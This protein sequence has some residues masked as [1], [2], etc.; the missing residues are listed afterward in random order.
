MTALPPHGH[1][2]NNA[3]LGSFAHPE[4]WGGETLGVRNPDSTFEGNPGLGSYLALGTRNFVKNTLEDY[5]N[6]DGPRYCVQRFVD[7]DVFD[8][9]EFAPGTVIAAKQEALAGR[10]KGLS[11]DFEGVTPAPV[12]ASLPAG[13]D[14]SSQLEILSERIGTQSLQMF[15]N[16]TSRPEWGVV[17]R[18]MARRNGVV[19]ANRRKS[20]FSL[21]DARIGKPAI[22]PGNRQLTIGGV[23]SSTVLGLEVVSR[24]NLLE[25]CQHGTPA[26]ARKSFFAFFGGLATKPVIN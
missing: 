5:I 8:A 24:T 16:Y 12:D 7:G 14:F 15:V 17:V 3:W 23:K 22:L 13:K 25:V 2:H 9:D 6:S 4:H 20:D 21:P 18:T 11:L 10:S 1:Y 26:K 19:L